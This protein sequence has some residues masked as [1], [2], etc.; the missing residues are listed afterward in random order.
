MN[1]LNYLPLLSDHER[2]IELCNLIKITN[3][4]RKN[5]LNQKYGAKYKK[6]LYRIKQQVELSGLSSMISIK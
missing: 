1:T 2:L 3:D 4:L 5:N 6:I